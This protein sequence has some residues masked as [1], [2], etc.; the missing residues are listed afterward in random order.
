MDNKASDLGGGVYVS[1][2]GIQLSLNNIRNN[3]AVSSGGGV[4]LS[5]TFL[6]YSKRLL[7]NSILFFFIF[8]I[9]IFYDYFKYT[10]VG[11]VAEINSGMHALSDSLIMRDT[12][13]ENING[14]STLPFCCSGT[15]TLNP[16]GLLCSM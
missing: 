2:S 9:I 11:N 12:L 4:F 6:P 1:S 5:S 10:I 16:N 7:I 15:E 8:F 13:L 14:N 3:T